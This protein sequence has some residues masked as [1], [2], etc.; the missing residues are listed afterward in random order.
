MPILLDVGF[1]RL[2][3]Q[4]CKQRAFEILGISIC[5]LSRESLFAFHAYILCA[6]T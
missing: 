4:L 3:Q 2:F 5:K 1:L 6:G